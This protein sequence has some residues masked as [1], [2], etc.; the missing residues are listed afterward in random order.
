MQLKMVPGPWLLVVEVTYVG[1]FS[2]WILIHELS[3]LIAG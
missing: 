2:I 1:K 3:M